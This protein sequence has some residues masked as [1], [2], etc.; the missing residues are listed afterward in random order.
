MGTHVL[1]IPRDF[2]ATFLL[3]RNNIMK[4]TVLNRKNNNENQIYIP[5]LGKLKIYFCLLISAVFQLD[6]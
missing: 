6:V 1:K 2:S 3:R 5:K 4:S